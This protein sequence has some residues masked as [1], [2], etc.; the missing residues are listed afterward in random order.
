MSFDEDSIAPRAPRAPR[1]PALRRWLRFRLGT[2]LLIVAAIA[3]LLGDYLLVVRRQQAAVA[4]V[5]AGDGYVGY[6]FESEPLDEYGFR[7]RKLRP[8]SGVFETLLGEDFFHVVTEVSLDAGD[9]ADSDLAILVGAARIEKLSLSNWVV[10]DRGLQTLALLPRLETLRLEEIKLC[11]VEFR[12]LPNFRQLHHL[13]LLGSDPSLE[14]NLASLAKISGLTS[15]FLLGPAFSDCTLEQLKSC[16][17]LKHLTLIA[18]RA[19]PTGKRKLEAA[20]P[21]LEIVAPSLEL[22][23]KLE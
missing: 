12:R 1:A 11:E 10:S 4:I 17:R 18:T 2:L 13:K 15:L 23:T 7:I 20:L 14:N 22:A 6:E 19:T 21:R 16:R 5:R 8:S 9:L 3:S